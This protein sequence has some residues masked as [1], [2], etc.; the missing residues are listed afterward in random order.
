MKN[1]QNKQFLSEAELEVIS[2]GVN[3]DTVKR[4]S[5]MLGHTI[6]SMVGGSAGYLLGRYVGVPIKNKLEEVEHVTLTS[7]KE[8]CAFMTG[9]GMASGCIYGYEI[10]EKI[11]NYLIKKLG[12]EEETYLK[13]AARK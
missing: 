11:G 6:G 2:G 9:A 13:K 5:V 4:L 12:L 7:D 8:I 10:G 3:A 1:L